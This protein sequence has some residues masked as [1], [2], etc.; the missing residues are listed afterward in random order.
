MTLLITGSTSS[1]SLPGDKVLVVGAISYRQ[2]PG[3]V[4]RESASFRLAC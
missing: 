1:P 2:V 3:T 4:A